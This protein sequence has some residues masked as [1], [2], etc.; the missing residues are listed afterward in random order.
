M[1]EFVECTVRALLDALF[2]PCWVHRWGHVVCT[3]RYMRHFVQSIRKR[4][5]RRP[6]ELT[7][8]K[9]E[10]LFSNYGWFFSNR[11]EKKKSRVRRDIN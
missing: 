1:M 10:A 5:V 6:P 3:V 2:W 7:P 9:I 11:L 4:N 8:A